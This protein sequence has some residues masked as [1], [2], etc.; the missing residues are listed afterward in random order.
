M[1]LWEIAWHGAALTVKWIQKRKEK[2]IGSIERNWRY[3]LVET[4]VLPC[5]NKMEF[6]I[7]KR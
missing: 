3:L 4:P 1:C 2:C 6:C 5:Y 7:L